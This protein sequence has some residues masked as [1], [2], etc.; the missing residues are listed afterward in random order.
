MTASGMSLSS[1]HVQRL[2]QCAV[3]LERFRQPKILPCQHTFCLTP[4]LEGLVD[5]RTRSIRCPECRAD[6]FVPRNGPSS[7]P[8]NLTVIGFLELAGP[9]GDAMESQS[10]GQVSETFSSSRLSE[11]SRPQRVSSPMQVTPEP[12]AAD[13]GGCAVCRSDGRVSRCCHCDQLVCEECRR[14]HMQQ[15]EAVIALFLHHGQFFRRGQSFGVV[16]EETTSFDISSQ[17]TKKKDY[18]HTPPR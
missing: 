11:L 3:C 14:S 9:A 7:F 12:A 13:S 17:E 6:H 8:N 1:E 4:C 5:R 16:F 2:L 18:Y 15:V 10:R